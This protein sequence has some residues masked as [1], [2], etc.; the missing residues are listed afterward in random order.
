MESYIALVVLGGLGLL[1]WRRFASMARN[2]DSGVNLMEAAVREALD[3]LGPDV[4]SKG[5]RRGDSLK[6]TVDGLRLECGLQNAEDLLFAAHGV[7]VVDAVLRLIPL[8]LTIGPLP[9]TGPDRLSGDP[10]FDARVEVRGQPIE[11]AALLGVRV[12]SLVLDLMSSGHLKVELRNVSWGPRDARV[13]T[14]G[15][16]AARV[17]QVID[18]ARLLR[19]RPDDIPRRLAENALQDPVLAVRVHNLSMLL[20][21]YP[22]ADSA[23]QTAETSLGSEAPLLRLRAARFL[24]T[25]DATAVL[26]VLLRAPEVDHKIR[27]EAMESL[28]NVLPAIDLPPLLGEFVVA[29]PPDRA[30]CIAAIRA[31][32]R[33]KLEESISTL[34][35]AAPDADDETMEALADAMGALGD[36]SAERVL[37]PR[38]ESKVEPTRLAVI[39]ALGHVGTA[40]AVEPLLPLA[41]GVLHSAELKSAVREAIERIQERLGGAEE[42]QLSI[43]E[44]SDQQGALSLPAGEGD[45]SM[46][47]TE[48][49]ER[50]CSR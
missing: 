21:S 18:L 6:A 32:G 30:M 39:R 46:G 13:H 40:A 2:F 44:I 15:D 31:I 16:L 48:D 24:G 9:L 45:L 50:T 38:L 37:L 29:K 34:L 35:E 36:P 3:Q 26:R 43:A 25:P 10:G 42:G 19:L 20:D 5:R 41:K 23:R 14:C 7:T 49:Q 12:R 17:R 27:L 47:L 33:R 28:A 1:V 11:V 4:K 8:G 22:K